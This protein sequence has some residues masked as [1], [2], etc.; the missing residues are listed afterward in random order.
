MKC[1][2][3]LDPQSHG[4]LIEKMCR[5]LGDELAR[6][7]CEVSIGYAG[8]EDAD[9]NHFMM[10]YLIP[11]VL[12]PRSTVAITHI[13]DSQRLEHA[14]RAVEAAAVAICMSSMTVKQLVND[15]L[16]RAKMCY[17]LPALDGG[18]VPRRI[19]I[20][21]TTR[22]YSDGRK[23][24]SLLVRL[25]KETDLSAFQFDIFGTGWDEVAP[26]LRHAGAL[27]TVTLDGK[28]VQGDYLRIRERISHFDYYLYLGLDEGSLGTLDA[29]A[30]GVKTIVTTQGFHV[31]LPHGITH[32][33][34]EYA[35]L[36]AVFEGIR[37]ERNS[38]VRAVEN[39]TWSRYAGRHLLIWQT[40]IDGRTAELPRLLG[41]ES[42]AP[43]G[44]YGEDMDAHLA[45]ERRKLRIRTLRRYKL[46]LIKPTI[47]RIVKKWLPRNITNYLSRSNRAK[48]G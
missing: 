19:V 45:S 13:D 43:L 25:A 30:A 5:R 16:P 2:L 36:R 48:N 40:I 21:L 23:R 44:G 47:K 22:L 31:D 38:R 24:E 11:P 29:L 10:Y 14:R 3:V 6:L 18:I 26:L 33:F 46:P 20:G 17:V 1:N 28:N 4:W 7:G 9:I 15:G 35:E 32:P 8:R 39:L 42:L 12:P 27:V 34:W 41:Q 37:E